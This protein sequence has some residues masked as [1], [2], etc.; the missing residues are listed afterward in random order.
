MVMTRSR[1]LGRRTCPRDRY[2]AHGVVVKPSAPQTRNLCQSRFD[3]SAQQLPATAFS[4]ATLVRLLPS[5]LLV[6][7]RRRTRFLP[8]PLAHY[9]RSWSVFAGNDNAAGTTPDDPPTVRSHTSAWALGSPNSTLPAATERQRP[10]RRRCHT[11]DRD[12]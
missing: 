9:A 7:S 12:L 8:A 1:G 10:A 4:P 11:H 2:D 6:P 5:S 3:R